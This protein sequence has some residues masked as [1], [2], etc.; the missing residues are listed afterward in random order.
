MENSTNRRQPNGE[1]T[2]EF[3]ALQWWLADKRRCATRAGAT[4]PRTSRMIPNSRL[5]KADLLTSLRTAAS[6][7]NV[8]HA[9]PHRIWVTMAG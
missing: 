1:P 6:V 4:R 7:N 2:S 5:P 3:D 8:V 9:F